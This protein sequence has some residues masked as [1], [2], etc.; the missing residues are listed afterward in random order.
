M[1]IKELQVKPLKKCIPKI[2]QPLS[3]INYQKNI[4]KADIKRSSVKTSKSRTKT[5]P[6]TLKQLEGCAIDI[7]S[8]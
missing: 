7:D 8:K 6:D 4:N 3:L 2:Y 1:I 5:H